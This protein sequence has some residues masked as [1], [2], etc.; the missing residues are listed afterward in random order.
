VP[1]QQGQDIGRP[2]SNLVVKVTQSPAISP[3][4]WGFVWKMG[5]PTRAG[6]FVWKYSPL[7]ECCNDNLFWHAE[8]TADTVIPCSGTLGDR[9]SSLLP[10]PIDGSGQPLFSPE[11]TSSHTGQVPIDEDS[12]EAILAGQNTESPAVNSNGILHTPVSPRLPHSSS[13]SP[14]RRSDPPPSFTSSRFDD[15]ILPTPHFSTR[16]PSPSSLL[17]SGSSLLRSGP[18]Q[19]ASL[20]PFL[21]RHPRPLGRI[22]FP[23]LPSPLPK[24]LHLLLIRPLSSRLFLFHLPPSHPCLCFLRHSTLIFFTFVK[25]HNVLYHALS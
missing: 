14:F 12:E 1:Q 15:D 24:F 10:F 25:S 13:F 21:V 11:L 20:P 18:P 3:D 17:R 9:P 2:T 19:Q 8:M 22:P 6:G 7:S 4:H 23:F 5:S 16:L